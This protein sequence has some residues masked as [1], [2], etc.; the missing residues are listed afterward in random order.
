MN[1]SITSQE[2]VTDKISIPILKSF[3]SVS[4]ITP[5]IDLTIHERQYYGN[6]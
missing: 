1:L 2:K 4:I 5:E 3:I 6:S